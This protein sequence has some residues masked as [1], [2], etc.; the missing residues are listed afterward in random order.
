MTASPDP[1]A[2]DPR[3]AQLDARF[4]NIGFAKA[5]DLLDLYSETPLRPE[6]EGDR[7]LQ[8]RQA[9]LRGL[10]AHYT[11]LRRQLPA[12]TAMAADAA[13]GVIDEAALRAII[14][15]EDDDG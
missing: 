6:A 4:R 1:R 12:A 7:P 15:G 2:L 3:A 11:L 5:Q 10:I 9:M 13:S 8:Q 14:G